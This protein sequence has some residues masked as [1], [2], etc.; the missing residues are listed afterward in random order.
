MG[1][2]LRAAHAQTVRQGGPLKPIDAY[3]HAADRG[4]RFLRMH[5]ALVN[6]RKYG[7]RSDWAAKFCALMHWSKNSGIERIDSRQAVIIL[8]HGA[9]VTRDDFTAESADDLLRAALAFGVSA[10]DRYIHERVVKGIVV[11]LKQPDLNY[12]QQNLMLPAVEA[13]NI[14]ERARKARA[15]GDEV[16]LANDVRK[17]VQELLHKRPFQSWREIEYAFKLLGETKLAG[18]LQHAYGVND[19]TPIKKQLGEIA[20]RRNWIV[21]EGDLVRHERGGT[22]R[23]HAISPK[24]VRDSLAF[25]D[26]F[27]GHLESV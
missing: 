12:T 5:D 3:T 15:G 16:R 18:K 1:F 24:F 2:G 6:T 17:V 21:H 25:L 11:A 8:R 7:I 22:C 13:I 23:C 27:V 9:S 26:D 19:M 14:T 4:R 10:L 20:K